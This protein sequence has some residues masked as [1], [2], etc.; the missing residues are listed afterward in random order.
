MLGILGAVP[1]AL[2]AL[3]RAPDR[4]FAI[5]AAALSAVEILLL[6]AALA[7]ALFA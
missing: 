1:L 7:L 5:A 6:L 4:G 2:W 3:R